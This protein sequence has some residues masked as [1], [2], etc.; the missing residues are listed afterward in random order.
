MQSGSFIQHGCAW[1]QEY[2][3]FISCSKKAHYE[4]EVPAIQGQPPLPVFCSGQHSVACAPCRAHRRRLQPRSRL[5]MPLLSLCAAFS[6]QCGASAVGGYP[7]NMVCSASWRRQS[8][9]SAVGALG[10][11][12]TASPW[13]LSTSPTQAAC[14]SCRQ[15]TWACSQR[16]L[17]F[18]SCTV[19]LKMFSVAPAGLWSQQHQRMA[20]PLS[21]VL[22]S[23]DRIL[24]RLLKCPGL[25][26]TD[27]MVSSL[28]QPPCKL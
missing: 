6:I 23:F 20:F 19:P 9:C 14:R 16:R 4:R 21:W 8:L 12:S 10:A 13:R 24:G 26:S 22:G 3:C 18:S 7:A 28:Q 17:A 27:D 5:I 11:S 1:L 15:H 25:D 2:G